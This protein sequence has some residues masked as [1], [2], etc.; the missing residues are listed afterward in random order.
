MCAASAIWWPG[1][2]IDKRLITFYRGSK[3]P[4]LC[5]LDAV[6]QA[7][8]IVAAEDRV[9]LP[10]RT[11]SCVHRGRYDRGRL[12]RCDS[13]RSSKRSSPELLDGAS[14]F[15]APTLHCVHF[16]APYNEH[17]QRQLSLKDFRPLRSSRGR[18]Q[19]RGLIVHCISAST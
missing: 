6:G 15:G 12:V 11:T 9:A 1:E 19:I 14:G 13:T 10:P 18:I 3:T 5:L 17:Y 16:E 8:T 7:R 2:I 4:T